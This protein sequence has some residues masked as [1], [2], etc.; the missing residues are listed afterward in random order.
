V[1]VIVIGAGVIGC[2]VA[3]ELAARGAQIEVVDPRAI[4][5][6]ATHASAGML[7]PY[8][9]GHHHG[10][11]TLGLASL[12]RY[13]AFVERLRRDSHVPFEYERTGTLQVAIGTAESEQLKAVATEYQGKGIACEWLDTSAMRDAA[14]LLS[15]DAT[16]ALLLPVQGYVDATGMTRA[17]AAAAQHRGVRFTAER[18][19]SVADHATVVSVTTPE[20][21]IEG[22]ALVLAAGS[23]SSAIA[24]VS[25][26]PPPVKP[27]RGQLLHLRAAS[28]IASRILWS[29][30]C[31]LVPWHNGTTLVGAT[32]EDVG[33][34]ERP[35]V[36][37]VHRLLSAA[38]ALLPAIAA[39]AFEDVRVGLRPKTPDELPIIGASSTMRRVFHATGHYRNGILL[40]PL[41]AELVADLVL[42]QRQH[43]ELALTSPSRFGL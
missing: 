15:R 13:D 32:V 37:G 30:Q 27:I 35:T 19:L 29:S 21:A 42:D 8:S 2:A 6:G 26:W 4:G 14:P 12:S 34:D 43:P 38:Q 1:K 28:R 25:S 40:T 36:D 39:A 17:L 18:V 7:A 23:W 5:A 10:L 33:F 9:E 16:A 11:L 20:G 3:C 24:G 41:T 22:D 31:Y